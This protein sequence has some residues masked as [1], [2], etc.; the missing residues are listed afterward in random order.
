[1]DVWLRRGLFVSHS[2]SS[3]YCGCRCDLN[4]EQFDDTAPDVGANCS[5]P[6]NVLLR[7]PGV[8]LGLSGSAPSGREGW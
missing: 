6:W 7:Q 1:M 8:M 5:P 4:R 3:M 2:C